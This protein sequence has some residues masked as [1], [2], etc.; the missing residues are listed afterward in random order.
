MLGEMG[1]AGAGRRELGGWRGCRTRDINAES[2]NRS[3]DTP[4]RNTEVQKRLGAN[5]TRLRGL[6]PRLA[7]G[8]LPWSLAPPA[9]LCHPLRA[10]PRAPAA[11]FVPAEPGRTP[12]TAASPPAPELATVGVGNEKGGPEKLRWAGRW[13]PGFRFF[14]PFVIELF[15]P[16]GGG[17]G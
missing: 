1:E 11:G 13:S 9:C 17:L 12:R 7:T 6:L 8:A 3:L 10:R 16:R 15:S 4:E 14:A 2:P 5:R